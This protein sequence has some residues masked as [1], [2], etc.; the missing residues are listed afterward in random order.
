MSSGVRGRP[1]FRVETLFGPVLN[2]E[3]FQQTY[4]TDKPLGKLIREIVGLDANAAKQAFAQFLTLGTLSADQITF[5]NQIIDHLVH[6][7]TMDPAD[8]FKPPFTDMHDQGLI[9]ILPQLAQGI[10]QTIRR[11]NENALVA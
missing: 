10:V 6:N 5:I 4:G 1:G 7:G 8:L 9:G 2:R 3:R 11:I